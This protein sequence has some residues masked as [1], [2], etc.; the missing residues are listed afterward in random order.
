MPSPE[1]EHRR[2]FTVHIP[3]SIIR[4]AEAHAKLSAQDVAD[5]VVR[6]LNLLLDAE[7]GPSADRLVAHGTQSPDD[8]S[9]P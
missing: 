8:G 4:R 9:P 2:R 5:I 6:A 1:I 7:N 3:D